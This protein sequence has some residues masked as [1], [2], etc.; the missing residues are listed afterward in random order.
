MGDEKYNSN[1]RKYFTTRATTGF[2]Y[3]IENKQW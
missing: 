3:K 1:F 2:V